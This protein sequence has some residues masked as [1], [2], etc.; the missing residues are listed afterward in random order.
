MGHRYK[1]GDVVRIREDL[2]VGNKYGGLTYYDGMQREVKEKGNVVTI[3]EAG[4]DLSGV[5]W[6]T[7]EGYGFSYSDEMIKE[8]IEDEELIKF[9]AFLREVAN[10]NSPNYT[11]EWG[12]LSEIV[13]GEDVDENVA[14]LVEFYK[15]FSPKT[16]KKLTM[17]ELRGI[18]GEDF[19][20]VD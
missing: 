20:I 2:T 9:E 4:A 1:V 6:Y 12:C 13:D 14:Q 16:K 11:H 17:A 7:F 3:A 19:E 10:Q 8:S 18:V 5:F 15:T